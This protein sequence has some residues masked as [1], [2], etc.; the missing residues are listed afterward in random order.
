ME[1]KILFKNEY[2]VTESVYIEEH[3]NTMGQQYFVFLLSLLSLGMIFSLFFQFW[4]SFFILLAIIVF[5]GIRRYEKYQNAK[6]EYRKFSEKR[7]TP[8]HISVEFSHSDF[9]LISSDGMDLVFEYEN[10]VKTSKRLKQI[11][12]KTD[13]N[14]IFSVKN[15]SFTIGSASGFA[16]FLSPRGLT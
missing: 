12:I 16:F 11:V 6:D 9:H 15:D 4:V 3:S 2:D 14:I 1:E 5:V 10:I 8:L 13:Q 7:K